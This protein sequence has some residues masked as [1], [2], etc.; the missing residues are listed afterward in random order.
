MN[1]T[2]WL[3]EN[4]GGK[5]IYT[6]RGGFCRRWQCDDGRVIRYTA[7]PVDQFDN[8][9]GSPQCWIDTPGKP[10]EPFNWCITNIIDTP[11]GK[12]VHHNFPYRVIEAPPGGF[13]FKPSDQQA[14]HHKEDEPA[15]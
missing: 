15:S 5:W 9:C 2:K 7:A 11:H 12:M 6:G 1:K 4:L 14:H 3:N 8:P 10:T 13:K